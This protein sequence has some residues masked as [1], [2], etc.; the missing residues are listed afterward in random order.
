MCG[1]SQT[2]FWARTGSYFDLRSWFLLWYALSA[3]RYFMKMCVFPNHTIHWICHRLT[4]S[5]VTSTSKM[6]ALELNF[7]CPRYIMQWNH[8]KFFILINLQRC[9]KPGVC[10]PLW[11]MKCRLM[12]KKSNLKQFNIRQQHKTWKKKCL[13]TFARH[14]IYFKEVQILC[15]IY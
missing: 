4:R 9:K 15:S 13:K 2:C 7:S 5:V 6:N 8:F 12:W 3:V 1:L 10:L 11:C 14:C